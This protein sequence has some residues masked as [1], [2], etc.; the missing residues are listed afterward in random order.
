MHLC[1]IDPETR[2]GTSPATPLWM[3]RRAIACVRE[4]LRLQGKRFAAGSHKHFMP[5]P[6][7][8]QLGS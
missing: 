7:A 2:V 4:A 8:L 6:H 3:A 1:P 5:R